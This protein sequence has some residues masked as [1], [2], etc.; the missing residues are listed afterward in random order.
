MFAEKK[1]H[2]RGIFLLFVGIFLHYQARTQD[3]TIYKSSHNYEVTVSRLDSILQAKG[4]TQYKTVVNDLE[5][6][7]ISTQNRVFSFE[8]KDLSLKIAAC[9]PSATLDLPLRIVVWSEESEVYLGYIDPSFM[10]RRFRITD[11]NDQIKG[12]TRILVRVINECIRKT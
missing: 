10:K 2:M 3:I 5:T 11:C 12:L 7:T 1:A 8:D 6:D 4:L 9:E